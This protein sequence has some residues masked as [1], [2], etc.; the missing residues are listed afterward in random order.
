MARREPGL[1]ALNL[2]LRTG[3]R[4]EDFAFFLTRDFCGDDGVARLLD[5]GLRL[6][7]GIRLYLFRS[8]PGGALGIT[9]GFKH[10]AVEATQNMSH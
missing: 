4:T 7:G 8:G 2:R 10:A 1:R 5:F 3:L 6:R 9:K